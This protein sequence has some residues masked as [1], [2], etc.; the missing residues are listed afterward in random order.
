VK[1]VED[2]KEKGRRVQILKASISDTRIEKIISRKGQ[3]VE[4]KMHKRA[5]HSFS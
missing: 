5:V 2:E 3:L 1:V 4:E